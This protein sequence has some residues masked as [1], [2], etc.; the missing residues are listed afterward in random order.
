MTGKGE[1]RGFSEM[2]SKNW[3]KK[4]G[5]SCKKGI[6]TEAS[7]RPK[8]QGNA[9]ALARKQIACVPAA[10]AARAPAPVA[11]CS[12]SESHPSR[13]WCDSNEDRRPHS[14]T[15]RLRC[16]RESLERWRFSRC[17]PRN[18]VTAS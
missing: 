5:E 7:E 18:A 15:L 14:R 11:L 10:E 3:E 16:G 1:V 9:F 17:L 13:L 2:V 8:L 6:K 4:K 12:L